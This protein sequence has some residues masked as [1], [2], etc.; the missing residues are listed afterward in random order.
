MAKKLCK[1]K[2]N[3]MVFGVC[4]GLSK[5]LDV[6][7][8]IIRIIFLVSIICGGLSI[9][10]YVIMGLILPE[11]ASNSCKC[12]CTCGCCNDIIEEL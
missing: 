8:S 12:N 2:K 3:A 4:S 9:W 6:D 5:Y 7:V 11:N 10:I 1:D